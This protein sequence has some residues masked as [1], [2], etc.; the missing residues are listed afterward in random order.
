MNSLLT[1]KVPQIFDVTFNS[2][3]TTGASHRLQVMGELIKQAAWLLLKK[4]VCTQSCIHLKKGLSCEKN[5]LYVF[6]SSLIPLNIPIQYIICIGYSYVLKTCLM[7]T[8]YI[9]RDIFLQNLLVYCIYPRN[10]LYKV[11]DFLLANLLNMENKYKFVIGPGEYFPR[12]S[13]MKNVMPLGYQQ[14]MQILSFFL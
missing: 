13:Q 9:V 12:M 14:I 1:S 8:V 10:T 7:R 11:F 3:R 5:N 6:I 2:S 4:N